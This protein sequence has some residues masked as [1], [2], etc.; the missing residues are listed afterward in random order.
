MN[1]VNNEEQEVVIVLSDEFVE[2]L[3]GFALEH[4][5]WALRTAQTEKVA[6][7]FWETHPP[8]DQEGGL[9]GITL[10]TGEGD[11]ETDFLSIIDDVELHHGIA[12]REGPPVS[13]LRVLGAEASETVRDALLTLGFTRI[14]RTSR[15]FLAHWHRE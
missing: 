7:E 14:E 2:I 8:L 3:S 6:R 4:P 15:G 9:G 12:A 1:S 10:F 11:P 13:V 5:V